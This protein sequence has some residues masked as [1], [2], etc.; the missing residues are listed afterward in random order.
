MSKINLGILVYQN[1]YNEYSSINVGDYIQSLAAINIYKKFINKITNNKY[2]SFP[3]FVNLVLNNNV[4]NFNFIFI[5]RDNMHDIKQYNGNTNIITIM[6]GWWMHPYNKNNDISFKIPSNIIPIFVS[7]HIYN[8]KL[9]SDDNIKQF[10]K[11]EPIGC[12]DLKTLDKLHNKG[13]KAYF[14]GCLTLTIDFFQRKE[15]DKIYF[16]DLN[17]VAKNK[18]AINIKHNIQ[19]IATNYYLGFQKALEL[20]KL[21]SKAQKVYTSRLHAYLPC[22]AMN[23]PVEFMS[24]TNNK[25]CLGLWT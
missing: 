22:I 24:N 19:P 9:L 20:L 2:K 21:Y 4:P 7:F 10:K 25:K 11:F 6:N 3:D 14:S 8:N 23:V 12:R 18:N 13:I 17:N 16:V 5:K 1:Q 15:G